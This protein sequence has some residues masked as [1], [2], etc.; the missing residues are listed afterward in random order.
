M[1]V[2]TSGCTWQQLPTA[3]FEPSGAT[4]HRRFAEWTKAR[5][6][7]KLYHLLLDE[8]GSC[9]ELNWS[10]CAIDSVNIRAMKKGGW[11]VRILCTGASTA[12]RTI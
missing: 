3:P 8:F 4:A 1:F 9:G 12:R 6:W 11:P 10:C 7:A 2:A 5:A